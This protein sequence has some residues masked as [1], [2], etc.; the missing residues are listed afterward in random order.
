MLGSREVSAFDGIII[1]TMLLQ[2]SEGGLLQKS[3]GVLAYPP[4]LCPWLNSVKKHPA[5][6]DEQFFCLAKTLEQHWASY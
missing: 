3:R 2:K 6:W 5:E 4:F 1:V